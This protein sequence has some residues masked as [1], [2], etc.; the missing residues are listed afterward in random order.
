MT[1]AASAALGLVALAAVLAYAAGTR[2]ERGPYELADDCPRGALVYAQVSDLPELLRLW[3]GSELKERYLASTNFRQFRN[4]HIALKLAERAGEFTDALGFT[5]AAAALSEVTEKKAAFAVYDI[6]KLELVFV[7]RVSEEKAL[8]ARFFTAAGYA[9]ETELSDGTVYRSADVEA[10]RGRQRQKILFAFVKGRFVLATSEA[11]MLRALANINNKSR[12]DRLT[13]EPSFKTLSRELSPHFASVWVDQTRLNGDY[14][15]KHYWAMGDAAR[16][17]KIRAGLF[18]FE[19]RDGSWIERREYL[20]DGRGRGVDGL[21]A[22]DLEALGASVPTEAAYARL[23]AITDGAA[24]A[25]AL[26]RDTLLDRVPEAGSGGGHGGE[27]LHEGFDPATESESDYEWN[28]GYWYLD[29]DYDRAIDEP[30]EDGEEEASLLNAKAAEGRALSGLEAALA[31][32]RPAQAAVAESPFTHDGPL[33]VEFRRLAVL[34]LEEPGG[35]DR[36]AFETAVASLVAGRLTV[37]SGGEGLKWSDG[38]EGARGRRELVL[39][40]L[41]WK[42]CYALRGREL[43]VSNDDALLDAA[44]AGGGPVGRGAASG[45]APDDVTVIRLAARKQAFDRVFARLD[46]ERVKE[47]NAGRLWGRDAPS[48]EFF[49]GNVASLLGVASPVERVEIRRRTTGGRMRVEVEAFLDR[50]R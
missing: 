49:S 37:A 2:R 29:S 4:G 33:F 16:L 15:F 45:F 32:A 6:G 47:Y 48:E 35:L 5:P 23:R 24:G 30:D 20:V 17:K 42:V 3:E 22:R 43:F 28:G 26:V 11:L 44:L 39:P 50:G 7:A 9:G 41:G 25:S 36:H 1:R 21:T 34:R 27:G 31:R 19:M 10:D 40:A 8:A 12:P 38:G 14:Y 13:D 46:A 18:D